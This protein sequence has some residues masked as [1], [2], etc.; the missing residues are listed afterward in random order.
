M[1]VL[2]LTGRRFGR[3]LCI[4]KDITVA[5]P[6]RWICEC[7]CGNIKSVLLTALTCGRTKSCGCLRREC[8]S[9]RLSKTNEF[10][11][12]EINKIVIIK[13]NHNKELIIS[14]DDYDLV[15]N[16]YWWTNKNYGMTRH[17]DTKNM[18]QIHRLIMGVTD[19]KI[20]IDHIDRNPLDN[21]KE[22]LR[23]ATQTQNIQNSTLRKC[24]ASGIIGVRKRDENET[25]RASIKY[26]KKTINLG[27]FQNKEDAII[28]RLKA[29]KE[30][31]KEFAPQRHLFEQY[32]IGESNEYK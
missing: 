4:K 2:D 29:E 28:E 21:R 13:C 16:Y 15:K 18:L 8:T 12:D 32:N 9:K 14:I 24:S 17:K 6:T 10:V 25:W 3:L 20:S 5:K 26:N 19:K 23:I 1:S 22:N 7:D 27:T 11:L 31:F 30:Y